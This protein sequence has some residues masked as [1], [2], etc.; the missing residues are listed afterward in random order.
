MSIRSGFRNGIGALVPRRSRP[1]SLATQVLGLFAMTLFAVVAQGHAISTNYLSIEDHGD[2][3]IQA[4]WDLGAADLHWAVGLDRDGDGRVTWGEVTAGRASIESLAL[5]GLRVVRGGVGCT[6]H[7]RDLMI[8]SHASEPSIS[9]LLDGSCPAAGRLAI[10]ST[11]FAEQ[12]ASQKTLLMLQTP[13]D[14]FTTILEPSGTAWTAP[15]SSSWLATAFRF[16]G[17]GIWHV[18]IGYDHIAFL[19]LLLLP[20]VLRWTPQGWRAAT[21]GR[22]AVRDLL[23]VVTAFTIA[24]SITLALAATGAARPPV[25]LIEAS[26]ALSIIAAGVLNLFPVAARWRLALA[27]GFGLMHGFGFANALAELG[28]NCARLVPALAGFNIGVELAQLSIVLAVFPWLLRARTS[29]FY[30]MRFLPATSVLIAM[31]G[32]VWLSQRI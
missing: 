29:S 13:Q 20:S 8:T 12:D 16:I 25:R 1:S 21:S 30:S 22:N 27:F 32:A 3:S 28:A 4:T 19:L 31:A 14:A 17:E 7:L 23:V 26:I 11:I 18:W 24:H 5:S 10:S 9:L 15:A 2:A 6:L